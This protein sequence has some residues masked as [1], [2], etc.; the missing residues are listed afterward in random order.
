MQVKHGTKQFVSKPVMED[1][2]PKFNLEVS[3]I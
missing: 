2:N 1:L 3:S